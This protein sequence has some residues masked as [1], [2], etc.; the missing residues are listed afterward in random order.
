MTVLAAP[1]L[2]L[3]LAMAGFLHVLLPT[4][5]VQRF[6]GRPGLRGAALAAAVGVPLPICSC[7]VLPLAVEM[8]RKKATD[9]VTGRQAEVEQQWDSMVKQNYAEAKSL[10]E[11]AKSML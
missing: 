8:K 6:L 1:F 4:R 9:K 3:G 5:V 2:L 10:A 7:G 11:K